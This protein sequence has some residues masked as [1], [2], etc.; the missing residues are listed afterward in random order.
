MQ[1]DAALVGMA[2]AQPQI[3]A[4]AGRFPD[5]FLR[6]AGSAECQRAIAVSHGERGNGVSNFAPPV[7]AVAPV[8]PNYFLCALRCPRS[9]RSILY[10]AACSR[11]DRGRVLPVGFAV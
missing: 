4:H 3:F 9:S 8:F 11:G 10:I 2:M 6:R 7:A 1:G 5:G